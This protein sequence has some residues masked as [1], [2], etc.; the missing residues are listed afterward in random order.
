MDERMTGTL[1]S[2]RR[3]RVARVLGVVWDVGVKKGER[4]G[5]DWECDLGRGSEAGAC[6]GAGACWGLGVAMMM[7]LGRFRESLW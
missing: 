5:L 6:A 7:V 4:C 2:L 1:R 3:C